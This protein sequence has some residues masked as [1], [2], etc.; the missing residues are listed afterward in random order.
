MD[1]EITWDELTPHVFK[2]TDLV[3]LVLSHLGYIDSLILN[4]WS[5][6]NVAFIVKHLMHIKPVDTFS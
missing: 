3:V 4:A 1:I 2:Y 6:L 5:E